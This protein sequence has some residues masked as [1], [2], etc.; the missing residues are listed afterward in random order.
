MRGREE[1][2]EIMQE[3]KMQGNLTSEGLGPLPRC[4][5]F[6][7]EGLEGLCKPLSQLTLPEGHPGVCALTEN[8]PGDA[9]QSQPRRS[10]NTALAGTTVGS[11]GP[12][13]QFEAP[14]VTPGLGVGLLLSEPAAFGRSGLLIAGWGRHSAVPSLGC[15]IQALKPTCL[16][17]SP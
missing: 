12:Q 13:T 4:L 3:R 11:L 16:W 1:E 7:Q 8:I 15:P 17:D 2:E 9:G 5:A 10:L 6:W 14:A